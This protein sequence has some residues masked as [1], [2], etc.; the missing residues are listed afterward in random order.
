MSSAQANTTNLRKKAGIIVN[1]IAI[2]FYTTAA[3]TRP[4]DYVNAMYIYGGE[5]AHHAYIT[6]ALPVLQFHNPKR[7]FELSYKQYSNL[8][9]MSYSRSARG[10]QW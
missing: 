1:S 5:C 3:L 10:K 6:E 9:L 8:V 2:V 4:V 7:R